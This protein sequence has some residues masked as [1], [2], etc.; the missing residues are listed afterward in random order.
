[1]AFIPLALWGRQFEPSQKSL[2]LASGDELLGGEAVTG[3]GVGVKPP[4]LTLL[5]GS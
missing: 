5:P 4:A 2:E 1:L 3:T